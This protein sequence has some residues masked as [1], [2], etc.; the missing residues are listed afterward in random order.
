MA[1]VDAASFAVVSAIGLTIWGVTRNKNKGVNPG[2]SEKNKDSNPDNG[3]QNNGEQSDQEKIVQQNLEIIH[4]KFDDFYPKDKIASE[5]A[6]KIFDSVKSQINENMSF[7]N[8][9]S[10]D[11]P[12][13]RKKAIKYFADII[14]G[15]IELNEENTD[16]ISV[17]G[18][19]SIDDF[20]FI[21]FYNKDGER[22]GTILSYGSVRKFE[23]GEGFGALLSYGSVKKFGIWKPIFDN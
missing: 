1:I 11:L 22:F 6:K 14:S 23:Y 18:S 12:Q 17:V 16:N 7:E 21:I 4:K 2:D 3:G 9:K 19:A 20:A 5:K 15:K 8:E 13:E 10:A